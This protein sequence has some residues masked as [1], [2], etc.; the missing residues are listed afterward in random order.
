MGNEGER[1]RTHVRRRV[2]GV[3]AAI[4]LTPPLL[5]LVAVVTQFARSAS[6]N[7]ACV[8]GSHFTKSFPNGQGTLPIVYRFTSDCA[9]TMP[10]NATKGDIVLVGGGGGGGPDGGSG[11]GGGEL[12]ASPSIVTAASP[13]TI[14]IGA[15]GQGQF[16]PQ[17][18]S[19]STLTWSSQIQYRAKGG[20]PG[21]GWNST[22]PSGGAGGNGGTGGNGSAGGQGGRGPNAQCNP[23]GYGVVGSNGPTSSITGTST[24]YGGGGAGGIGVQSNSGQYGYDTSVVQGGAGG[25]GDSGFYALKWLNGAWRG[26]AYNASHGDANTGGGGGGAVACDSQG[27]SWSIRPQGDWI[28][29]S[30]QF[31][32]QGSEGPGQRTNGGNGGSGVFIFR[33]GGAPTINTQPS[34]TSVNHGAT[35]TFSVTASTSYSETLSYQWQKAESTNLASWSNI[36][37]ATLASYTTPSTSS[38]NDN[39]DK[40][41]VVVTATAD[42]A[43]ATTTSSEV[44][45]TVAPT[46]TSVAFTSS[47]GLDDTYKAS[48]VVSVTVGFS[49]AVT[50]TSTPRLQLDGLSSK[51]V[52][53]ASG[54]GT[55]S[56]VFSYTIVAGDNDSDGLGILANALQLNGGTIV[57]GSRNATLTHGAVGSQ[58]AHKV[59]TLA[60]SVSSLTRSGSGTV[61]AGSS[62]TVSFTLS[63]SSSTFAVGDVSVTGGSLSGFTGSGVSYSATFTP[64]AGAEGT[65]SIS[66]PAGGF[67]DAAGNS[68]T[69][70]STLS[71]AYDTLRPS[72]QI[73]S[74][75]DSSPSNA[76][77][78]TYTITFTESVTGV[79]AGDFSNAG[80]AGGCSFAV[81]G[82]GWS[83]TVTVSCPQDGTIQPSLSMNGVSDAAGNTGPSANSVATTTITKDTGAPTVTLTAATIKSSGSASVSS[84]EMGTAYL[85]RSSVTVSNLASITGAA[86]NV[87]NQVSITSASTSTSLAATGL[88]D[89]TYVAYSVDAAGN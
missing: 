66:V 48:D 35:A 86:D 3:V 67:T 16:S 25:G 24:N 84:T 58:S 72:V 68:N 69:A 18:G 60:P 17:A 38:T 20:L 88:T 41:R 10:S 78:F 27:I 75:S 39:G 36:S 54:S 56:L 70:S 32:P 59:D 7:P 13:M 45:L 33:T 29:G 2:V 87:W 6:A 23:V 44:G 9:W 81:S 82:S 49:E 43:T 19:D 46:V 34:A 61:A 22:G 21:S 71:I 64:T 53:Y 65:A 47:A 55:S 14:D 28:A 63:E 89:G 62:V 37:G 51:F 50:V 11:G 26:R 76:T 83:Y 74:S 31:D 4:L 85:V 80:S 5:A 57:S 15:G 8:E 12:R 30:A 52:T 73:F 1:T 77:S 79:I 40:Y 42:G